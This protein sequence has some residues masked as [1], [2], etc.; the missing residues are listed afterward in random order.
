MEN[1]YLCWY[2]E[3]AVWDVEISDDEDEAGGHDGGG[4]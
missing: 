4:V 2:V 1:G 3:R